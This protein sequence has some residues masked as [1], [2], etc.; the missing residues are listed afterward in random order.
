MQR[1]QPNLRVKI[2]TT[3]EELRAAQR[4][5]YQVFV[6]E[7]GG[8]GAMVDHVMGLEADRFDPFCDHL[9]LINDHKTVEDADYVIGVYRVLRGEQAAQVG[10]FYSEDEYDLTVLKESGRSMLELGRSC[11][12]SAHRGGLAMYLLWQGLSSYIIENNIEILFGVASFHGTDMAD[13]AQ[14]LALLHRDYR[15]PKALRVSAK[16]EHFQPMDLVMPGDLERAA[17]MV[18][19]PSLIKSYLRLGGGV[20]EGAFVDRAFNTTDICMILDIAQMS[21]RQ[22]SIYARGRAG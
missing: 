4:L 11:V 16:P 13:L 20:G 6:E 8:G 12:H 7:L 1:L 2:A 10:Q 15:A 19:M 22:K 5:R 9:I 17:A 21:A 3:D 14:P 18:K